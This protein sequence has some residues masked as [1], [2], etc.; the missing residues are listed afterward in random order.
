MTSADSA[1]VFIID[2]D[3]RMRAATQRLLKSVGVV[4]RQNAVRL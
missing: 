1:T 4:P 2:D 3:A